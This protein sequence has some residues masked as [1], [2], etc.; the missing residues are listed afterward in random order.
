MASE[1]TTLPEIKPDPVPTSDNLARGGPAPPPPKETTDQPDKLPEI[2]RVIYSTR[3]GVDKRRKLQRKIAWL[4]AALRRSAFA[5]I[6]EIRINPDGYANVSFGHAAFTRAG[7]K[8]PAGNQTQQRIMVYLRSI[9]KKSIQS[10]RT[11]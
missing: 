7:Q 9:L 5:E 1:E 2:R 8:S 4:K 6:L 11:R 10:G 3:S